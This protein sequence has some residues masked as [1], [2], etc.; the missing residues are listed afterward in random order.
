LLPGF[1][2]PKQ[3]AHVPAKI[4]EVANSQAVAGVEQELGKA[5]DDGRRGEIQ[6]EGLGDF[7][8]ASGCGDT[9]Q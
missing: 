9:A 4:V 8:K 7:G 5:L 3:L 1:G 6:S 2:S